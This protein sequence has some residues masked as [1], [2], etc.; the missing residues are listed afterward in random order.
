MPNSIRSNA[1][2]CSRLTR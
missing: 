1:D 2:R